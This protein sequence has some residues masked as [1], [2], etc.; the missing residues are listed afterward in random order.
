MLIRLPLSSRRAA[1]YRHISTMAR[2][3]YFLPMISA[4]LLIMS[5]LMAA[6]DMAA[7]SHVVADT[8][9]G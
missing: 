1:A 3:R 8:A 4:L 7:S 5:I 9:I 6:V 2:F